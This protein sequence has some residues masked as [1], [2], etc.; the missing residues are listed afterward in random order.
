MANAFG[1]FSS[2]SVPSISSD[3]ATSS[4]RCT[5]PAHTVANTTPKTA[6]IELT[7]IIWFT[8]KTFTL[9]YTTISWAIEKRVGMI[10]LES[11]IRESV[12]R[13][14]P[15]VTRAQV[16]QGDHARD[17]EL[18]TSVGVNVARDACS[19]SPISNCPKKGNRHI[20]TKTFQRTDPDGTS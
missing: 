4:R 6:S 11:A 19:V 17:I 2:S 12:R 7:R 1:F 3:S 20:S 9:R 16:K 8:T 13:R 10:K 15:N 5:L 18:L 14:C